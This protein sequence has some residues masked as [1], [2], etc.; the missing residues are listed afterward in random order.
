[1]PWLRMRGVTRPFPPYA[2]MACRN[3]SSCLYDYPFVARQGCQYRHPMA[4]L[5]QTGASDLPLRAASIEDAKL[6]RL[7][8]EPHAPEFS[9]KI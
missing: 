8:Y 3:L 9:S 7:R 1:V 2:L 5:S 6:H 4:S